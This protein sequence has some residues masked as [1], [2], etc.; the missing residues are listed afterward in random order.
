M[1]EAVQ[2][3]YLG[4]WETPCRTWLD[5]ER[6]RLWS[7]C[8]SEGKAAAQYC[9]VVKSATNFCRMDKAIKLINCPVCSN[10]SIITQ[11]TLQKV[12]RL[13]LYLVI[14]SFRATCT[15]TRSSLRL[16]AYLYLSLPEHSLEDSNTW[17]ILR[18]W[19]SSQHPYYVPSAK[20]GGTINISAGV[21]TLKN[22][23]IY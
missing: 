20:P 11:S 8:R 7:L 5:A 6:N 10:L 15:C 18:S 22:L 3:L 2:Y 12:S 9:T 13:S 17:N 23:L 14:Y 19:L 1:W 16:Q 4:V 21:T